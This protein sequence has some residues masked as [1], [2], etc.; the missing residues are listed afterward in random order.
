[1]YSKGYPK[2]KVSVNFNDAEK[3][4]KVT[5]KQT[6]VSKEEPIGLFD[7]DIPIV[8]TDENGKEFSKTISLDEQTEISSC[9][10]DLTANLKI[11]DIDPHN[12]VL[13]G[14]DGD[15]EGVG[16][17]VLVNTILHSS[18][19]CNKIYSAKNLIKNGTRPSLNKLKQ[20]LQDV[21][22]KVHYG[23]FSEVAKA[24]AKVPTTPSIELFCELMKSE[25]NPIALVAFTQVSSNFSKDEKIREA[26]LHLLKK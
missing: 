6:Q 9:T 17:D 3:V 14:L 8:V 12:H 23:L 21:K 4:L 11:F 16:E 15:Y 24:L 22:G 18:S 5:I 25:E 7:V 10:F 19:L 13:F 1:L 26:L 2:L 20:T